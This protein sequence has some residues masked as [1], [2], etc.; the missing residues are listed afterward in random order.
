MSAGRVF[1]RQELANPVVR[2]QNILVA[3]DFSNGARATLDY[4]LAIARGFQSQVFLVHVIPTVF[5]DYVSSEKREEVIQLA[6]KFAGQKMQRL[7]AE[8]CCVGQ[9]RELILS[10]ATVWP[11]LEEF[12]RENSIDLLVL[13]THGQTGGRKQLLGPLAEEIFRLAGCPVLTVGAVAEQASPQREIQRI[14]LATNFKPHAEYAAHF[15]YALERETKARMD[16]LHVVEDRRELPA[17]GRD[18]VKEF[19]VTRMRKG[20]PLTCVGKCEP[21]FQVRFGEASDQILKFSREE[22]S[23]LIVLGLLAGNGDAGNLPSAVAYRLVCQAACPVLTI[24]R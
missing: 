9:V 20:M 11:M 15:A 12:I 3:T 5:L 17:G 19:M 13:G 8:A 16:V 4:A 10:G 23:D 18:I 1:A 14:L 6:R 7:V 24:R 22:Q 2:F 21:E